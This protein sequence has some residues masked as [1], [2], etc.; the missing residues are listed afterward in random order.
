MENRF[1]AIK[2]NNAK[3]KAWN[4]YILQS[5][6]NDDTRPAISQ[7]GIR[8]G[9]YIKELPSKNDFDDNADVPETGG[10][11]TFKSLDNDGNNNSKILM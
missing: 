2:D 10:L 5:A 11:D 1:K 9:A 3:Q 6:Y 7:T 8:D 4:K